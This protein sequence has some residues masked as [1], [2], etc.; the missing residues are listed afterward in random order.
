MRRRSGRQASRLATIVL[1]AV[2]ALSSG[3]VTGA[4]LVPS[5]TV[6]VKGGETVQVPF[7]VPQPGPVHVV[8]ESR[9]AVPFAFCIRASGAE[10]LR[11]G[12][13]ATGRS[14]LCRS[15]VRQASES[16]PLAAGD[17][18]VAIAC[19]ATAASCQVE[20]RTFAG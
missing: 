12:P 19:P 10:P 7:R 6:D 13:D 17:W 1:M 15:N 8:L 11:A 14:G 16:L 18:T 20:A 5:R 3:C 2:A 9:D 4:E